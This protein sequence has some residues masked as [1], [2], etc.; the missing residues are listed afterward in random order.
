MKME[1]KEK[2]RE[3]V[4]RIYGKSAKY[5]IKFLLHGK[6]VEKKSEKTHKTHLSISSE[7]DMNYIYLFKKR[8][9]FFEFCSFFL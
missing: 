9:L 2:T 3:N 4:S 6:N 8:M 7:R 5:T 1:Y